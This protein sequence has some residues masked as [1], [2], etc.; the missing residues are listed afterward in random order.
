MDQISDKFASC[1]DV[2]S[3]RSTRCY[4]MLNSAGGCSI[5]GYSPDTAIQ[6]VTVI[7]KFSG[8]APVGSVRV[9]IIREDDRSHRANLKP[10]GQAYP[11]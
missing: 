6:R 5:G 4:K 2:K 3:K 9:N 7:N 10:V 8:V 1:L 11:G